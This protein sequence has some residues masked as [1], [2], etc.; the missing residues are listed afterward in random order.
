MK[1]KSIPIALIIL[2]SA[3]LYAQDSLT[4]AACYRMAEG[5]FP[6]AGQTALIDSMTGMKLDNIDKAFFPQLNL[7]AQATYQ[8]DIPHFNVSIP[9]LEIP[10]P[11]KDQYKMVLDVKQLIY[12]GG[13][14]KSLK[15]FQ[16]AAGEVQKQ[17]VNVQ[18]YK[19]KD[20][21][22]QWYFNILYLQEQEKIIEIMRSTVKSKMRT[23]MAGIKNGVVL[24]GSLNALKAELLRID[25]QEIELQSYR[26]SAIQSLGLLIGQKLSDTIVLAKPHFPKLQSNESLQGRP[27]IKLYNLE[28]KQNEALILKYDVDRMP[29]LAAFGQGG[30]GRPGMN[31]L[32][33]SWQPFYIA[34][35][36][37]SWNIWDWGRS[38]KEKEIVYIN[39]KMIEKQQQAFTLTTKLQLTGQRNE[40]QK[41][42]ALIAKD[43][44]IIILQEKVLQ[45]A[46]SQF[47]NGVITATEYIQVLHQKQESEIN[48]KGHVIQLLMAK[49]RYFTTLGNITEYIKN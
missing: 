11:P 12:D 29:K 9:N 38:K 5:N 42:E 26:I 6:L 44:E 32:D 16:R 17:E 25:Q 10:L 3:R 13:K 7:D 21:I 40:I 30:Y 41:L 31:I 4:L 33:N 47:D 2:F 36:K 35:L 39:K 1:I 23:L 15:T 27:E 14:V 43:N 28:Q 19:L 45:M 48:K 46:A 18:M 37:L 49:A 22:N 20:Q 8:S 24:P 34:G